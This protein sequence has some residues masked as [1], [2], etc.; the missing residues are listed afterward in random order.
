MTIE[1]LKI[2]ALAKELDIDIEEAEEMIE[3][4]D[5][6]V[7][8]DE[9]ADEQC[10]EYI[11]DSLW[12]FNSDFILSECGLDLSGA[13]SLRTMQEKSC[14]SANDFVLSLVE[15]TCGIESFIESAVSADGRGH[16]MSSYDGEEIEAQID[17]QYLY[18]YRVN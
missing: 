13:D 9:E 10:A 5:Y 16:F 18:I 7:L 17:G 3:T 1:E 6:T 15:K 12:A 2:K 14:K 4:G 11:K 8:T